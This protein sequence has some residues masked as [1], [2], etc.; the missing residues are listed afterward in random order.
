MFFLSEPPAPNH[1]SNDEIFFLFLIDH[2]LQGIRDGGQ[3]FLDLFYTYNGHSMPAPISLQIALAKVAKV[4]FYALSARV[5]F[6]FFLLKT[7]LLFDLLTFRS[8]SP[9]KWLWLPL[10]SAL[11]FSVTQLS[12]FEFPFGCLG[13]GLYHLGLVLGIWGLARFPDRWPGLLWMA[14]GGILASWSFAGGMLAWP[15]LL[16]GMVLLDYSKHRHYL[17][18]FLSALIASWPYLY[19]LFAEGDFSSHMQGGESSPH[20]LWIQALGWPMAG[21]F[22]PSAAVLRGWTGL[23]LLLTGI[24]LLSFRKNRG[25][26]QR[27]APALMLLAFALLNAFQISL[28]RPRLA[29]WYTATFMFFWLGLVALAQEYLAWRRLEREKP[30]FKTLASLWAALALGLVLYF[31]QGSQRDVETYSFFLRNRIPAAA[32]CY[33]LYETAPTYC[34]DQILSWNTGHYYLLSE[35]AR[36]LEKNRLATF[37]NRQRWSLQGD[38]ISEQVRLQE[39]PNIPDIAWSRD[40]RAQFVPFTAPH[41]LN[42]F[43]HAPNTVEWTV[44]LPAKLKR[45]ELHSAVAISASAPEDP[46]ADGVFFEVQAVSEGREGQRLFAQYLGPEQRE[47]VP[48][49]VSLKPYAGR[50]VTLRFGSSPG[51]NLG[52]D[53]TMLRFPYIDL[54]LEPEEKNGAPH[55]VS[56][57]RPENTDLNPLG[58]KPGLED[59]I[60]LPAPEAPLDLCLADFSHLVFRIPKR[61][62]FYPRTVTFRLRI[63]G[64]QGYAREF[65]V[66]LIPLAGIESYRFDLKLLELDQKA[67]L[68]GLEILPVAAFPDKPMIGIE[69]V[70]LTRKAGADFCAKGE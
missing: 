49:R 51:G 3:F 60:L 28:L 8:K 12:I 27:S 24:G 9:W 45:A 10:I 33:R 70:R 13:E 14:L 44:R 18:W 46:V 56:E 15:V 29:P 50:T 66:P 42:L 57:I 21:A 52:Q 64:P 34:E 62:G 26:L 65:S 41:R 40:L 48:F 35:T 67:R 23:V 1:P 20:R 6:L 68:T 47:W 30:G 43:L 22:S 16:L 31:Y 7:A 37:G 55:P 19:F 2:A 4:D 25:L 11:C 59:A 63:G 39:N 53:W 32:S 61:A 36:F 58:P 69:A 38:F 54:E 5:G 17:F